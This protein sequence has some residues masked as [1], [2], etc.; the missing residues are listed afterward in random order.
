MS[1]STYFSLLPTEKQ[2][3]SRKKLHFVILA[4]EGVFELR[5]S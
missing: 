4:Q 5:I 3:P 1:K 2:A